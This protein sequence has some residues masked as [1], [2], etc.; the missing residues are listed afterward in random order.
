MGFRNQLIGNETANSI[1]EFVIT[2]RLWMIQFDQQFPFNQA[3]HET[4]RWYQHEA[5]TKSMGSLT[6]DWR[7]ILLENPPLASVCARCRS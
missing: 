7:P 1:I 5:A 6:A 2:M 3:L 4:C